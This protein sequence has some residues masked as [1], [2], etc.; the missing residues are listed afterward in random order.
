MEKIGRLSLLSAVAV[1]LISAVCL[2]SSVWAAGG[3]AGG[4]G[5]LND[6]KPPTSDF[7][8]MYNFTYGATWRYDEADSNDITIP[9][10]VGINGGHIYGCKDFGG[11]YYHLGLEYYKKSLWDGT[12]TG[13][14]KASLGRNV[15]LIEVWYLLPAFKG[16][17]GTANFQKLSDTY[18]HDDVYAA[19]KEVYDFA[20]KTPGY[21]GNFVEWV[22]SFGGVDEAWS[23]A[24]W[25]CAN[26]P[27][28]KASGQFDG[29]SRVSSTISSEKKTDDPDSNITDTVTTDQA[30]VTVQFKHQLSYNSSTYASANSTYTNA[31]TSWRVQVTQ[32]GRLIKD[33]VPTPNGLASAP[34]NSATTWWSSW[35]GESSVEVEIPESG[36]TTVCSKIDYNPK[37]V[38][39]E[40][41]EDG[42][43]YRQIVPENSDSASSQ[44]CIIIQR[45]TQKEG[46]GGSIRF[47]STSH[48]QVPEHA[49]QQST[50]DVYAR[51]N[52]GDNTAT[53][54]T[55][56]F[57][58]HLTVN[59]DHTLHY[60]HEG[61]DQNDMYTNDEMPTNACT[62]Y[63]VTRTGNGHSYNDE[64][65]DGDVIMTTRT[66]S[67]TVTTQTKYCI[68]AT[69]HSG[70]KEVSRTDGYEIKNIKKGE[71]VTV[72][73]KI[74]FQPALVNL[75][76]VGV[77]IDR[78]TGQRVENPTSE[79]KLRLEFDHWKYTTVDG[80]ESGMGSS[81]VCV[82]VTRPPDPAR[83]VFYNTGAL[84][85]YP[86]FAGE[87]STIG[88]NLK[89][90]GS[91]LDRIK[92]VRVNTFQVKAS[93]PYS[94]S[95]VKG[96]FDESRKDIDPCSYY[97]NKIGTGFL[98]QGGNCGTIL[99]KNLG[100]SQST[101]VSKDL[102]YSI[103]VPNLVGDKYCITA[104]YHMA[105]YRKEPIYDKVTGAFLGW[106]Y[107]HEYDYWKNYDAACVPI[108]KK[109]TLNLWNGGL[110]VG[111]NSVKTSISKRNNLV[112]PDTF[113]AVNATT[114]PQ[115][116][117]E[118]DKAFGSWAEYLTVVGGEVKNFSSGA[119]FA[120]GSDSIDMVTNLSPLTIA[121][122]DN[123]V[124][125]SGI[126]NSSVTLERLKNYLLS[127]DTQSMRHYNLIDDL[128]NDLDNDV[129]SPSKILY[130]NGIVD[131]KNPITLS[132]TYE[133]IYDLP[134][135]VIYARDGINIDPS[136]DQ[137]DAW[138]ITEGTIN[139]CTDFVEGSTTVPG[140]AA[141]VKDGTLANVTCNNNLT[142]NG[143]VFAKKVIT[144]R[145]YGT[146][147]ISNGD[148][149]LA[150][151]GD[152]DSSDYDSRAAAAEI[153]NLSADTY[154]WAY[155]QAG[156]YS[157]S[158][159]EAY[160]REL[161]PRY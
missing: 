9:S 109:P 59:F 125:Y 3:N 152:T 143:P 18:D 133:S 11:G 101:D 52:N 58:D 160:S 14:E 96:N 142:I 149:N 54:S 45:D 92:E 153:F 159:N 43:W 47:S 88:Y 29:Y 66:E 34:G 81:T 90:R 33:A 117:G 100:E 139:T 122:T 12:S 25:F 124:G 56:T 5:G 120:L 108:A 105:H 37:H 79:Q 84:S 98:R 145:T 104:G 89:M 24:A 20:K 7:D 17:K 13:A 155:A 40:F 127:D 36:R 60:N 41:V 35:L 28:S 144:N 119:Q 115:E 78:L 126:G 128:I 87:T 62:E 129:T 73:Q 44:A 114:Q 161:P 50:I 94:S 6:K 75:N 8:D 112:N 86:M 53:A 83:G 154:L 51:S 156:R 55:S 141:S 63:I 48:V 27:D 140:T 15:G 151:D 4:G 158:Y 16:G 130:V 93:K 30:K 72:C 121:N 76:R 46:N 137:I 61:V 57:E 10:T 23:H 65:Y 19:F 42:N 111:E 38:D 97:N 64:Q 91:D 95:A 71:T 22:E 157:S 85:T 150:M 82:E 31:T 70:S 49:D 138:L 2:S 39:W 74:T 102:G 106:N 123:S 146:D 69:G 32:D 99:S 103:Y 1:L 135:I 116:T 68:S 147:G 21:E 131:I 77:Y 134:Q 80:G 110:F 148:E 107:I 132:G 113:S 118:Y 26:K 136:V 67:E